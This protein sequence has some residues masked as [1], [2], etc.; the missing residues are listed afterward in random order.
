MTKKAIVLHEIDN[1]GT[2]VNDLENGDLI[3]IGA[4]NLKIVEGVPFGHKV[5]LTPIS[6]GGS[7]VKYG[8]IIGLA[9]N[10][11]AAGAWVHVHNVESQ[12]GRG[13]LTENR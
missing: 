1:V 8:E 13:D 12:R 5:A 10:D 9:K 7:V 6:R 11:I 2:A 4:A 3:Q